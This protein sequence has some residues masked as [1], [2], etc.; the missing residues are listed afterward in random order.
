[1]A[2]ESKDRTKAIEALC[3]VAQETHSYGMQVHVGHGLNYTNI[4]MIKEIPHVEEANIG[5][6]IM[7][8]ALYVGLKEAV[9]QMRSSMLP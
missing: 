7:S 2:K 6:S 4:G 8:R 9:A 3:L 5:H 1:M